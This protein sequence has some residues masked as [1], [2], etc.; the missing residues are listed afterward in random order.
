MRVHAYNIVQVNVGSSPNELLYYLQTALLC[1]HHQGSLPILE[2]RE[3]EGTETNKPINYTV[4]S[5][6]LCEV[7]G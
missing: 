3:R 4:F 2:Q 1:R 7:T 5:V 6:T